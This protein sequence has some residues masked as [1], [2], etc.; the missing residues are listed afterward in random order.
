MEQLRRMLDHNP[1]DAFLLYAIAL[2]YKKAGESREAIEFLDKVIQVDPAYCYAY[3][4][5][6]L[7]H[8]LLGDLEAAR[9]SYRQGIEVALKANDAH[10]RGEIEA[11]LSLI[12]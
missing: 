12:Q 11:A 5:R 7:V 6:G 4:Q 10:A 3:H 1:N 9:R 2:E 8:E